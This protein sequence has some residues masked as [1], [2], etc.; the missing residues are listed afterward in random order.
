MAGAAEATTFVLV[1]GAWHG[2]W[3]WKAV[4]DVLRGRG[5][6]VTTPTQTG[7]GERAHLLSKSITLPVFVQDIVNH[8]N[9]EDLTDV[10]LVGHSFGGAP[11]IGA[12][13]RLRQRIAR[14]ILL[15]GAIM[16]DGETWFGLLPRDIRDARFRLARE[17]SAG[18]SL[19]VPPPSEFGVTDPA[20][21]KY[22]S[23][24]LTPHPLATFSTELELN[25]PPGNGLPVDYIACTQP[26]HKPAAACHERA[27]ALGWPVTEFAAAHDA[28]IT[29]PLASAELL[30]KLAA[31]R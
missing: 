19:P 16:E 26:V 13:D 20:Q 5:H 24:K 12:A 18:M 27:K 3:C 22:L 10:I 1:H 17:T 31:A 25:G 7:L 30:E 6:R 28:M 8:L 15:D 4:A 29:A 14:L 9:F 21:V 2:G 23:A 11:A